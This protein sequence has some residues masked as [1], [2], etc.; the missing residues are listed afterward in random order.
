MKNN[1]L[2]ER[3]LFLW[4]IHYQLLIIVDDKDEQLLKIEYFQM[5]S[6]EYKYIEQ[7]GIDS[8]QY[9]GWVD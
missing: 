6:L 5:I 2:I 9:S 7:I 8:K 1:L 4:M 3:L